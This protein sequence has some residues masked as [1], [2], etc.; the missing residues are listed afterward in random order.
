M[1][2]A[3]SWQL[4]GSLGKHEAAGLWWAA[5]HPKMWP[6]DEESRK[7]IKASWHEPFGDRRQEI[8]L[9][10]VGMDQVALRKRL[11]AC[12]LTP[13]EMRAGVKA[14]AKLPDPFPAWGTQ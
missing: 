13:A 10:G 6:Q 7:A 2:W 5:A 11:D 14:W 1:P 4:A 3:G 9:I 12:L 8:V